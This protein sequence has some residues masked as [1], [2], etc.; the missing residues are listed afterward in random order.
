MSEKNLNKNPFIFGP[1]GNNLSTK[2]FD[3]QKFDNAP[4]RYKYKHSSKKPVDSF[5]FYWFIFSVVIGLVTYSILTK[6]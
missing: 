6:V 5:M 3:L 1:S 4:S 2:K